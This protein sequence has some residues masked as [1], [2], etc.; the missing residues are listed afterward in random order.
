MLHRLPRPVWHL[1]IPAWLLNSLDR[2]H[3]AAAVLGLVAALL[4]GFGLTHLRAQARLDQALPLVAD[5]QT[6]GFVLGQ[7]GDAAA[8]TENWEG[9]EKHYRSALEVH[10]AEKN[11][12]ALS[13]DS[14]KLARAQLKRGDE[15]RACT[16]LRRARAQ[17]AVV[18]EAE[19]QQS[20]Q[21]L[22]LR[23]S[24]DGRAPGAT[25]SATPAQP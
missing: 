10:G 14:S 20:C 6:R 8:A 24:S 5:A 3:S 11:I 23:G 17:G 15:Q 9:A 12:A 13:L 19:L 25:T 7:L 2:A 18:T 1:Y 22:R 21:A 4:L 16:T